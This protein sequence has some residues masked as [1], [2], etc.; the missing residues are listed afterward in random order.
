MFEY[1]VVEKVYCFDTCVSV[2]ARYNF[3]T[4]EEANKYYEDHKKKLSAYFSLHK[5]KKVTIK[6]KK[7]S[8]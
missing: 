4:E 5:P 1:W 2:D 8:K 7:E 3:R 6:F